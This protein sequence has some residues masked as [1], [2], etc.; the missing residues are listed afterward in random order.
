MTMKNRLLAFTDASGWMLGLI[1]AVTLLLLS[2]ATLI[3][4]ARAVAGT[5]LIAGMVIV[6]T[7]IF[8]PQVNLSDLIERANS[9]N[10]AAGLVASALI[11]F[12][13]MAFLGVIWAMK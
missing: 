8:F 11:T 7:R 13:G 3:A 6:G 5:T 12:C 9:G 4:F 2:P 1:G 10:T